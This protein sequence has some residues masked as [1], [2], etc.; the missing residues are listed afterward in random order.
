MSC[1]NCGGVLE[2]VESSGG[3]TQ[4]AF[5]E[6]YKCVNC[7]AKGWIRGESSDPPKAW[8]ESGRA[9]RKDVMAEKENLR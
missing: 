6:T 5:E 8:N 7:G 4:G 3:T 9:L 1:K 2:L